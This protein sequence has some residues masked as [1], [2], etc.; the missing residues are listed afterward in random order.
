MSL[1]FNELVWCTGIYEILKKCK[2]HHL[3]CTIAPGRI[4]TS[5]EKYLNPKQLHTW[6]T[7]SINA[8]TSLL[9]RITPVLLT[10]SLVFCSGFSC[11]FLRLLL[12]EL[13]DLACSGFP[14]AGDA[15]LE[16]LPREEAGDTAPVH[17]ALH[18]PASASKHT[19]GGGTSQ[20]VSCTMLPAGKTQL[21]KLQ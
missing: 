12:P 21:V 16:E 4:N 1:G 13:P 10:F 15:A 3:V 6:P 8:A 18:T 5:T 11:L 7:S 20:P 14:S 9:L 17:C 2:P 19:S